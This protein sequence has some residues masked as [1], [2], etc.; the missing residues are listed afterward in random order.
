MAADMITDG[1][2]GLVD[3]LNQL[4][5]FFPILDAVDEREELEEDIR[6]IEQLVT[7]AGEPKDKHSMQ[8]LAYL[9]TEL[10]RKRDLLDGFQT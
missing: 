1:F 10:V 7:V 9:Q 3:E 4:E 8:A 5:E 6:E 2:K